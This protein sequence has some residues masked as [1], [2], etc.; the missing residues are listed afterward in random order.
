MLARLQRGI[1]VGLLALAALWAVLAWRAGHAAWAFGGAALVVFGYAFV[2]A[3]EFALLRAAHGNDPTPRASLAQLARAWASEVVAAPLVFGWRQPFRSRRWPDRPDAAPGRRGVVLVHGFF[4]NR[5]IWNRWL[6]RLHAQ[7]V[8]CV[9]VDLEP[10]FGSIDDYAPIVEAAVA[11]LEAA[12]GM[13]PVIVAHSMGG[14]AVRRWWADQ[15]GERA[16]HVVTIATPH[17]G[18]ALAA[19]ALSPNTRQ[20]RRDSAWLQMLVAREEPQRRARM[21]CFYS[22]S[23]N[24]VFPPS[25]ATL[26]GARNRHIA[27]V[28]HVHMIDRPEPWQALLDQLS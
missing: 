21:T 20:M 5:G 12:T 2:L 26:E 3:V 22:A 8:P 24:I 28:P 7:G 19:G 4:C 1:V 14:L 10:V 25:T 27:G 6:E 9:A 11:R 13:E 23:D 18:T 17:R 16:H 15:R